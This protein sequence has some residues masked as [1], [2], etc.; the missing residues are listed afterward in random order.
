MKK[1]L[2]VLLSV[3]F[4]LALNGFGQSV[5]L[6]E[7]NYQGQN[8]YVQNPYASGGVGFCVYEIRVNGQIGTDEVGSSAFIIDLR[9]Y[10]LKQGAPVSVKIFH[11]DG[12]KPKVLNADVLKSK[13]TFVATTV[14]VDR[15]EN[16]K[17]ITTGET[18]KLTYLVEQFRWNK[19]VKVG[20]V[21]GVGT[22]GSN[23]YTFKVNTHSGDNQ[24]RVK[25]VDYTS[26]PR[27]SQIAKFTSF[28]PV[29]KF[30]PVKAKD[31]ITFEGG[32]TLWEIWDQY[33]NVV[34]RGYGSSIDV[35]DLT[36]G[37][38]FL[39]YDAVTSEFFKQ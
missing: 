36:K 33:G 12:C 9:N 7:G 38:Y 4:L 3:V 15:Q 20:E 8:I 32:D 6:F 30:F 11:K 34:K 22:S 27:L 28:K 37:G 1:K 23:T 29:I 21:E 35:L 19:W 18:G 17:W 13:S 14:A 39:N 31:K 25:Q 10:N 5:I 2:V 24:F 26:H 16:L